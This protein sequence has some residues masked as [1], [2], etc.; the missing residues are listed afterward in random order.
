MAA[1]PA[2]LEQ[3]RARVAPV[4]LAG[5]RTFPAPTVLASVLSRQHIVRGHSMATAGPLA[6]TTAAQLIAPAVAEGAWV[7]LLQIPT[8]GLDA[9][10][11]C[12]VAL[13]RVVAVDGPTTRWA[14]LA[15]AAVD[16]FDVVLTTLPDGLRP[17]VFRR[18]VDRVR[19]RGAVLV[20]LG[21]PPA[22]CAVDVVVRS[23]APQWSGIT[24]GAGHLRSC[25]VE[26]SIGGRRH[27]GQR[28]QRVDISGPAR[29]E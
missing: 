26:L 2:V 15:A 25:S 18:L 4:A 23:A 13:E 10:S 7:C 11:E 27:G 12:G 20:V 14:E 22:G 8:I 19:R 16:G 21:E 9:L 3:L 6:T 17:G 5:E 1:S 24:A 28:R 29:H